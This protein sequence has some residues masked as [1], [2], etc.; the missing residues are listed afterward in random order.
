MTTL[1]KVRFFIQS[2]D[3]L[4]V[5]DNFHLHIANWPFVLCRPLGHRCI[6]SYVREII[7]LCMFYCVCW[8][9]GGIVLTIFLYFLHLFTV[10][11]PDHH[12]E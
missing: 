6:L 3:F 11:S 5:C 10:F 4:V 7:I 9:F 1:K 2:K 8:W 12:M